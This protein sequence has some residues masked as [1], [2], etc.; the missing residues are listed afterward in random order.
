MQRVADKVF[1]LTPNSVSVS[2]E[3]KA[4]LME[5]GFFNQY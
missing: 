3:E 4:R 2:A 5:R 1:L